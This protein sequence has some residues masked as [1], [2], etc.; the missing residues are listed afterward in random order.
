MKDII[1]TEQLSYLQSRGF[2]GS[3][4]EEAFDWIYVKH[5]LFCNSRLEDSDLQCLNQLI[6]ILKVRNIK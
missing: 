1:P 5:G 4:L 3:T 6:Q 2:E